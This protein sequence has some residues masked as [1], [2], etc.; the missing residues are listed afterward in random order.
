MRRVP[1]RPPRRTRLG[2]VDQGYQSTKGSEKE[3][4]ITVADLIRNALRARIGQRPPGEGQ[5]ACS[6]IRAVG[7]D[8]DFKEVYD[9]EGQWPYMACGR[10]IS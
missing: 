9:T 10:G 3:E 5:L 6:W 7:E 4:E 2:E 1:V 8:V